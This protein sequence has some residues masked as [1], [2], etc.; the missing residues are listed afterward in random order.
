G[1]LV[2]LFLIVAAAIPAFAFWLRRRGRRRLPAW[3]E[4]IRPMRELLRLL[5]EAPET[6]L[7]DGALLAR[8]SGWNA[9]VFLADAAT[10]AACLAAL[11]EPVLPAT[12][13]VA[14]MTASIVVTLGPIP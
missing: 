1:I 8:V 14:F 9:L 3:I 5:G 7:R 6:L 4:R 12:A 13:F 11:G 10:L 2:T